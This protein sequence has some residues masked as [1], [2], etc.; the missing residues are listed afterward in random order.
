MQPDAPTSSSR[1]EQIATR[2]AE[3]GAEIA[4]AFG[5]SEI[6]VVGL[7]KSCLVFM[8][9]LIRAIP[10]DLTCPLPAGHVAARGGGGRVRT[11][12]VYSTDDPLRGPGHPAARR[13]HRHRD[14]PEL[15]ARPHPRARPRSLKVCALIDKPR[16]RKIDVHP[17]WARFHAQG[18]RAD[19]FL[20]G[21][22]L[23]YAE[24]YRGLPYIG[25]HPPAG[26]GPRRSARSALPPE[27]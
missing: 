5:G 7:M 19:R 11:D 23:D 27:S 26:A 4:P 9:D 1:E 17:D 15:P 24:R 8:A 20:V 2:I 6:C 13:H 16:E 12:I 3:L 25:H 21:Y 14:H 18:A 10:S 22:G